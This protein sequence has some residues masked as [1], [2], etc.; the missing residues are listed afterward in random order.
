MNPEISA[1]DKIQILY[2]KEFPAESSDKTQFPFGLP[3]I[4]ISKNLTAIYICMAAMVAWAG[5]RGSVGERQY[6]M[7]RYGRHFVFAY[8]FG[9]STD[10]HCNFRCAAAYK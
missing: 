8:G 2:L 6:P 4:L 7:H 10:S 3:Y 9:N 5:R 1:T